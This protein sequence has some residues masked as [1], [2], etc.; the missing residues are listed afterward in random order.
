MSFFIAPSRLTFE[1]AQ[2]LVDSA[3]RCGAEL[4]FDDYSGNGSAAAE[5]PAHYEMLHD[6]EEVKAVLTDVGGGPR[7]FSEFFGKKVPLTYEHASVYA[8]MCLEGKVW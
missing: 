1:L 4:S 7:S 5:S 6:L 2:H 8:T 3:K